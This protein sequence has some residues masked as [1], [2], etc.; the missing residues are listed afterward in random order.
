MSGCSSRSLSAAACRS[1]TVKGSLSAVLSSKRVTLGGT[2]IALSC[3]CAVCLVTI[4]IGS[5]M[6]DLM[7]A[8]LGLRAVW[9]AIFLLIQAKVF[10]YICGV[11]A[12]PIP[13]S[14]W[15]I[16]HCTLR[17]SSSASYSPEGTKRRKQTGTPRVCRMDSSSSRKNM[18]IL[19]LT[20][21]FSVIM[22]RCCPVAPPTSK[23]RRHRCMC[24]KSASFS[25]LMMLSAS[26]L[27]LPLT[28]HSYKGFDSFTSCT[29]CSC[30]F[31][32]SGSNLYTPVSEVPKSRIIA[33]PVG[34]A[35]YGTSKKAPAGMFQGESNRL[36]PGFMFLPVTA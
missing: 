9:I 25:S 3:A 15:L 4:F 26:S 5:D 29:N 27:T 10:S 18:I 8:A 2:P 19:S 35:I 32:M 22:L 21:D 20:S 12:L 14:V 7:L 16:S 6:V 28:T 13:R 11:N 1:S 34:Q 17:S 33:A 24:T 36:C 23:T 31:K 30:P